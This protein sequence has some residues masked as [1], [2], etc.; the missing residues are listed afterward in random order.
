MRPERKEWSEQFSEWFHRVIFEAKVYDYRY[1]VKG[2]AVWMP[3]GFSIRRNVLTIVRNVLESSGHQ[4]VLF[5]LLIP[6]DMLRREAEHVKSFEKEVFW[7]T[8][9]GGE[10]L[11]VKLALRP[12]SETAIYPMFKLWISSYNDLP[13]KIYQVVSVFRHE[14][15]ATKPMIRVR[16]VTTFKEAHTAHATPEEAEEQVHEAVREYSKIF[17]TLGIPYLISRRPDW[18]KFP[19]AVYTI[20]FDTIMPD[21][22]TLQIG[23]V[24]NL[25]Q[26]FSK[27]FDIKFM[28][29]DGSYDYVWQT[30]Y[31]I[32]ERVVAALISVHGDD[33]GMVLPP[34]VAPIHAV[35]VPI[36]Y[37]DAD[38]KAI[39]N[40]AREAC[41]LLNSHGIKAVID[42][43]PDVTPGSKYFE[44]ELKG[45]PVRVEIGPRDLEKESATIVKRVDL[46]K[47]VCPF[48]ELVN[49]VERAL[50]EVDL[51]L[52]DR[53]WKFL[54][55]KVYRVES[56]KEGKAIIEKRNGIVEMPWCLSE[57]CGRTIE[58]ELNA[59]VLGHPIEDV[60]VDGKCVV[61]GNRAETLIRVAKTY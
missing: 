41:E 51:E 11:N 52:R 56:L 1:P 33:H 22:R 13:I 25:G 39:F 58:G 20:A 29:S 40:K 42:D 61:C 14:T 23:T 46:E 19:G 54:K 28:K 60:D 53:A 57:S 30:C 21:G 32:S 38:S 59:S 49:A 43:R 7:V 36:P 12:T 9:G 31:G 2:M 55:D 10:E 44:W 8:R 47:R 35:V 3:Y 27:A 17:D 18:D 37:K 6:E 26:T 15:K 4:E 48:K 24:H 45:V 50:E 34:K 5:P 16:E